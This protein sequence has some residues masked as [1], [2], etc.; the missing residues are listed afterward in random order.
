[1]KSTPVGRR[2]FLGL[3]GCVIAASALRPAAIF[4]APSFDLVVR[5][6]LVLDGT[7]L[8][9]YP[10]DL[11]IV[12]DRIA[13][14][15]VI[16][17]EQGRRV[18]DVTGLHVCPGFIDIHSHSDGEILLYPTADSRVRQGITTELTGNC[19]GSAAPLGGAGAEADRRSYRGQGIEATWT[20]VASY[21]DF[22]G[23]SGGW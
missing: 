19:G 18:L 7:G 9:A 1:M 21:C 16:S 23:G 14:V 11:G 3:G 6:G 22:R 13:A 15:G 20:G 10:A 8:P 2:D 17:T 5:G 12:A 4:A